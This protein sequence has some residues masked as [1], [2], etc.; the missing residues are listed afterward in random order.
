[1][2]PPLHLCSTSDHKVEVEAL[3]E[4]GCGLASC[5]H[6]GTGS[7]WTQALLSLETVFFFFVLFFFLFLDLGSTAEEHD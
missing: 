3:D 5:Q 2:E 6:R 4:S 1:M 7:T